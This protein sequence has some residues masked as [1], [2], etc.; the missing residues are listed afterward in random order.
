MKPIALSKVIEIITAIFILLFVYMATS[1]LLSHQKFVISLNKSPLLS[2]A[3]G[4]LSWTIPA[5]ELLISILLFL[6]YYRKLGLLASFAIMILFTVYIAYT[7]IASSHL[8]CSCGGM[9]S[10]LNWQQHLWLNVFLT[11]LAATAIYFNNRL[12]FLL[13]LSCFGLNNNY[14]SHSI[15]FNAQLKQSAGFRVQQNPVFI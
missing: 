4:L 9:I 8:P 2:F 1:K 11:L 10:T 7:L 12:K 5:I 6:P 3:S 15:V 13:Q 14:S